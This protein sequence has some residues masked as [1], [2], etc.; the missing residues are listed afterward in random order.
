[1]VGAMLAV[2]GCQGGDETPSNS[3]T[4]N[5]AA[6]ATIGPTPAPETRC[7]SETTYTMIDAAIAE[8][9]W[10]PEMRDA[11][12]SLSGFIRYER[13]TIDAIHADTGGVSCSVDLVLPVNIIGEHADYPVGL[14]VRV[15]PGKLRARIYFD[16]QR[17][18][19]SGA[20]LLQLTNAA[21]IG[22]MVFAASAF[23][24]GVRVP[25]AQPVEDAPPAESGFE[26]AE[27]PAPLANSSLARP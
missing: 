26:N 8:R 2:S 16:M 24:P 11:Q 13:P 5:T 6:I 12:P 22:A 15:E 25:E 4:A 19:D 23:R 17:R 1:M 3:A 9:V 14:G 20:P 21:D 10:P 7:S 18:V 27:A